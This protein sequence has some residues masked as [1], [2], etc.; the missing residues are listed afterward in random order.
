MGSKV[1]S[2]HLMSL[3]SARST[4]NK[5][6][7]LRA[8]ILQRKTAPERLSDFMEV[9]QLVNGRLETMT[10]YSGPPPSSPLTKYLFPLGWE[11]SR[12]EE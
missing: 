8:V 6:R 12:G 11:G 5:R 4:R 1:P 2:C 3:L 9:T 10:K 7:L